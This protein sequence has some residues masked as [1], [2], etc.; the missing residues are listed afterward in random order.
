VGSFFLLMVAALAVLAV[1]LAGKTSYAAALAIT[2][3]SAVVAPLG[4]QA[5]T[6]SGGSGMGYMFSLSVDS[7][8]GSITAAGAYT[9]GAIGGV[10]DTV[11]VVDSAANMATATVTVT[12]SLEI[13]PKS[14]TVAAGGM[15]TFTASGGTPPYTWA[16]TTAGSGSMASITM[17]GGVY[18]AGA[19]AG[20]DIVTVTDTVGNTGSA[21]ITVTLT[22]KGALGSTCT[23]SDTCP[24]G[25]TCVDGVCCNTSCG[26]QCQ[27]CNTASSTG[28][29]VTISG[30][31]V[32]TRPACPQS[33]PDDVCTSKVCDG[34]SP[35]SCTS[36]AGKT[37]SCGIAT[38]T[39]GLGTPGAVCQGDGTCQKVAVKSCGAYACVSDQCASTCTDM[40]ECSPGNYC[41]VTTGKCIVPPPV[42]DAG[43]NAE[44]DASYTTDGTANTG[45]SLRGSSAPPR[46]A[47][48]LAGL[49][50][51]V[52]CARLRRRR[53]R[54]SRDE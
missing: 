46:T 16:L 42:P 53:R 54:V 10:M 21:T 2:P 4:T 41:D 45:C 15:Q 8:G 28:T 27:A 43:T 13:S 51:L 20:T 39:D 30:S 3:P 22:M 48:V 44:S 36:F 17:A 34:T 31:P 25:S 35:T 38:C 26:G 40:S 33:D 9:A 50:G 47:L 11:Q 37:T 23:T 5:F 6:A 29:C 49:G 19:M 14:A 12:G 52:S 24:T 7:S 1:G 18:T 32:G